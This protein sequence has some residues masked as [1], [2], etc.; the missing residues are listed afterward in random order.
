MKKH[1][2]YIFLIVFCITG[3]ML[4]VSAEWLEDFDG[5]KTGYAAGTVECSMGEWFMDDALIG[6]TDGQ[7]NFLDGEYE[8][9][10]TGRSARV[11]E[12][13]AEMNFDK[14]DGAG[15]VSFYQ[16]TWDGD[17]PS[18]WYLDLSTDGGDNWTEVA[19]GDTGPGGEHEHE[20]VEVNET[21]NIR[22]R[23]RADDND[24][25][26]NFDRVIITDF[27]EEDVTPSPSFDP[28]PGTFYEPFD[29]SISSAE[30]DAEIWYTLDGT[31]PTDPEN[32]PI[33]YDDP[34]EIS[35]TTTVMAYAQAPEMQPS[36]VVTGEFNFP[37]PVADIAELRTKH[38]DGEVYQLTGE[39]VITLQ[40]EGSRNQRFIQDDTGAILIDDNDEI[41]PPDAYEIG[42]V[43]T[44]LAGTV[45]D[46]G[47]M[48]QIVPS[49]DVGVV[50]D[51][52]VFPE[53]E[54]VEITDLDDEAID[55]NHQALLI[56]VDNVTYAGEPG[57]FEHGESYP[58]EDEEEN[59]IYLRTK[60]SNL[61]YIGE[62]I[63]EEPVSLTGVH[64]I[65]GAF[66]NFPY[67][68]QVTPR[69]LDD[70]QEPLT[71]KDW[72]LYQ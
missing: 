71:V 36:S 7:D 27:I 9:M 20:S 18:T 39:A 34:F 33:E 8:D 38:G 10:E 69:S 50:V 13:Y 41:I 24:E 31:D 22:I 11:R 70:I 55:D 3:F 57:E 42:D 40:G 48:V 23:L 37:E 46:F 4:P 59:T 19:S 5:S 67:D 1:F 47:D 53:P 14:S 51:S 29:L 44:N 15:T 61:D 68:L 28:T 17:D 49:A 54:L 12:G 45:T 58:F 26:V 63:P 6:T 16:R 32:D 62:P 60:F 43:I 64:E 25:R 66:D 65:F 52:D 56:T 21:G 2:L 35:E 30:E 72:S